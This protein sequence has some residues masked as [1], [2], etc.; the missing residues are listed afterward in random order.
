MFVLCGFSK[1]PVVGVFCATVQ[2][3]EVHVFEIV[4]WGFL[5]HFR[6]EAR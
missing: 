6:K 4:V 5:C 2:P 1:E 3:V